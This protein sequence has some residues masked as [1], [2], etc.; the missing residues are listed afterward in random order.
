MLRLDQA[1]RKQFQGENMNQALGRFVIAFASCI[2]CGAAIAQDYPSRPV[3]IIVPWAAGGNIDLVAR[4][5]AQSM[6]KQT[7]R[8]FL[9]ENAPGA[10]SMIG[11]QRVASA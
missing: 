1:H 9:I 8:T 3:T 6:Q 10:G 5:T 11:T 7:G 2:G 4:V